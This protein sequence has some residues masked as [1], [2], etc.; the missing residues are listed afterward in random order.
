MFLCSLISPTWANPTTLR[1]RNALAVQEVVTAVKDGGDDGLLDELSQTDPELA[2]KALAMSVGLNMQAMGYPI[3]KPVAQMH[4]VDVD[5]NDLPYPDGSNV[6]L[7]AHGTPGLEVLSL[8]SSQGKI[9][10]ANFIFY[11][12]FGGLVFGREN[13][14]MVFA[15]YAV[16]F[17]EGKLVL[18]RFKRLL[19]IHAVDHAGLHD[20]KIRTFL[21]AKG[22]P[23]LNTT[24]AIR[25]AQDKIRT[26]RLLKDAGIPTPNFIVFEG[27][28]VRRSVGNTLSRFIR[29]QKRKSSL[30]I[31]PSDSSFGQ[32]VKMFAREELNLAVD[33]IMQL[34]RKG[35]RVLA[36]E[37]I[38]NR[39]WVDAETKEQI[40]WNLRVLTTWKDDRIVIDESMV[41]VRY[42]PYNGDPVN[43]SKGAKV[44]TLSDFFD[45]QGFSDKKRKKF[46]KEVR[47]TVRHAAERVEEE[48]R[49]SQGKPL[50]FG[51]NTGLLGW[52]L[53]LSEENIWYILEVNAESV[54]GISTIEGKLDTDKKGD[55][56]IPV[57]LFLARQAERYHRLH[58]GVQTDEE[59]EALKLL[60]EPIL[61]HNLSVSFMSIGE[62]KIAESLIRLALNLKP[63]AESW[64][65]LGYSLAHQHKWAEAEQAF[66][67]ALQIESDNA[68]TLFGL[69]QVS[70]N[71]GKYREAEQFYRRTIQLTSRVTVIHLVAEA[72]LARL[73]VL[74]DKFEEAEI[75]SR[76]IIESY[77]LISSGELMEM[78]RATPQLFY[79]STVKTLLNSVFPQGKLTVAEEVLR[80]AIEG[81]LSDSSVTWE[82]YGY[83]LEGLRKFDEA[84]I[85]YEKAV[86]IDPNLVLG[87]LGLFHVSLVNRSFE[88]AIRYLEISLELD[89]SE[90]LK[91]ISE[92]NLYLLGRG[93]LEE[94]KITRDQHE[95]YELAI[96]GR[97]IETLKRI[98][99]SDK[100]D[101]DSA[102]DGGG[103]SET[104]IY[105]LSIPSAGPYQRIHPSQHDPTWS[106]P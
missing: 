37:R 94:G 56:A 16:F 74:Q 81:F 30:V 49:M 50:T 10:N 59:G 24:D 53:I 22:I 78:T 19:P 96:T 29:K 18:G 47:D 77:P 17:K 88:K 39:L 80:R 58:K 41:E 2:L 12:P 11:S 90:T 101:R 44:I 57:G 84:R 55:A 13:P 97:D 66:H 104:R 51:K 67:Q 4:V 85:A 6:A 54:G 1:P 99:T 33:H 64:G 45:K 9:R 75:L 71:Q 5:I 70:Q 72:N 89:P 73:L 8:L 14:E 98:V 26:G 31:K 20:S 38:S 62:Y 34:L 65:A 106:S 21:Q 43:K 52:D 105:H 3:K 103:K 83:V 15:K 46:F 76:S 86:S 42:Q 25:L 40:D 79:E 36:Q 35:K 48:L 61:L 87:Y 100:S 95:E 82:R 28:P 91:D 27:K 68:I 63:S 102:D 32:G 7:F 93:L 60:D 92:K 23:L 69:G